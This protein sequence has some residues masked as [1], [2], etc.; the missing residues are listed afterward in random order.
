MTLTDF[1]IELASD[2]QKTADFKKGPRAVMTAAG[3]SQ[4]DQE[5]ILSGDPQALRAAVD[6][7]KIGDQIVTI[8]FVS[9]LVNG[10]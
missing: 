3:L 6:D 2:P 1:L 9:V 4:S 5:L 10:S 8:M 7:E